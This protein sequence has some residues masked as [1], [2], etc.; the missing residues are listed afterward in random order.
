M[1]R[2]INDVATADATTSPTSDV[3]SDGGLVVPVFGLN[4][5]RLPNLELTLQEQRFMFAGFERFLPPQQTR[6]DER[7]AVRAALRLFD[8]PATFDDAPLEAL[9]ELGLAALR[10]SR[11]EGLPFF[12]PKPG[13]NRAIDDVVRDLQSLRM[14]VWNGVERWQ[15]LARTHPSLEGRRRAVAQLR[16]F[17]AMLIPDTRGKRQQIGPPPTH[18]Q[19]GYQQLLF[20]LQL[21]RQLSREAAPAGQAPSATLVEISR[22]SGLPEEW[23]RGWLFFGDRWERKPRPQSLK[24]MALELL[25]G[26]AG[27]DPDSIATLISR[28]R[29]THS[30]KRTRP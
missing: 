19:L 24:R 12:Q 10:P 16:R 5:P 18:L 1:E 28:G 9:R 11:Q 27:Q 26:I 20:R 29:G 2:S 21:A 30:R 14:S 23:V 4:L 13:I 7:E 8:D 3:E 25:A 17:T 15:Q 6:A 22:G